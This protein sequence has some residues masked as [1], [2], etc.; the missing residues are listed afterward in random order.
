[1]DHKTSGF[2]KFRDK[3]E[4]FIYSVTEIIEYVIILCIVLGIAISLTSVA[5]QL[6]PLHDLGSES[7]IVF[8]KYI[9]NMVI[10]IELVHL[11]CH[12]TL[13]TVVQILT[14]AITREI[15]IGEMHTWEQLIGTLAIAV[16]F[17]IRK[18]LYIPKMDARTKAEEQTLQ[19]AP[20]EN[21]DRPQTRT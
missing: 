13:D 9:I 1:L 4:Y 16:L 19:A 8:L 17:I 15:I 14:M 6:H 12:Q 5:D 18:Y 20:A 11:L 10:A 21:G 3:V 7:L 2:Q